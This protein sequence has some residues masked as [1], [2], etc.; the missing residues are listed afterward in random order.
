VVAAVSLRA[1]VEIANENLADL[2]T[3]LAMFGVRVIGSLESIERGCVRLIVCSEMFPTECRLTEPLRQVTF[4]I[5]RDGFL[6]KLSVDLVH[7]YQSTESAVMGFDAVDPPGR[8]KR[9]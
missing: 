8:R 9:P 3:Q 1:A 5:T 7:D 6:T 4:T 2:V